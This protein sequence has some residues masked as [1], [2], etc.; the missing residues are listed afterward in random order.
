[1][2]LAYARTWEGFT[3]DSLCDALR[4]K[5]RGKT[6][7]KLLR[8]HTAMK[9]RRKSGRGSSVITERKILP[10]EEF[11]DLHPAGYHIRTVKSG[12]LSV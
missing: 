12:M 1:M 6:R 11:Q 9:V 7:R 10:C 3:M 8:K 4:D 5:V 2:E